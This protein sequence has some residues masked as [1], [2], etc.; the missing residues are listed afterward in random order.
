VAKV[1][2]K[3][4]RTKFH[5]EAGDCGKGRVVH[6]PVEL[7]REVSETDTMQSRPGCMLMNV[8]ACMTIMVSKFGG[9]ERHVVTPN[10]DY[11]AIPVCAIF[12]VVA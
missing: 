11:I 12:R 7:K 4:S 5:C 6:S 9:R 3:I 2:P 10:I 8:M 1:S